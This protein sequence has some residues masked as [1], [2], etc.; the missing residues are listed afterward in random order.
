MMNKILNNLVTRMQCNDGEDDE[1]VTLWRVN[2]FRLSAVISIIMS[3]MIMNDDDDDDDNE[4][5]ENV[6][7]WRS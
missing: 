2:L 3:M 1:I 6:T 7:L 5:E 4:E